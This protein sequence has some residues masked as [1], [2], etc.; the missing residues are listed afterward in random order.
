MKLISE[1]FTEVYK[2]VLIKLFQS[3]SWSKIKKAYDKLKLNGLDRDN[4]PA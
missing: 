2:K 3:Y 4:L 1:V